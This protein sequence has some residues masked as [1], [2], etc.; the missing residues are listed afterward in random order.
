MKPLIRVYLIGRQWLFTEPIATLLSARPGIDL[1]GSTTNPAEVFEV[2][3]TQ[4][5]D[6]ILIDANL[7]QDNAAQLT[8]RIRAERPYIKLIVFGLEPSDE[9]ILEFIEAGANGC[10]S[11]E[12]SFEDLGRLIEQVYEGRTTCSPR[13]AALVFERITKLS[14]HSGDQS[15]TREV[16]LTPREQEILQLIAAGLSNKE[17]AQHLQ[18]SLFTVKNHIH[19]LF[20]KLQVS[21]RLEAI[22][23]AQENG[24][25][26]RPWQARP[27]VG[28]VITAAVGVAARTAHPETESAKPTRDLL[29]FE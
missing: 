29:L 3:R 8:R 22:R 13:T 15:Q 27:L 4:T 9:L 25:I 21:Y 7:D 5:I 14:R 18:I 20:E 23:Y 16:A 28:R 11:H 24:L 6:V 1:V 10:I 2:L 12:S 19:N 26:K 17:I